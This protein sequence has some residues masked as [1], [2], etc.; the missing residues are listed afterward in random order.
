MAEKNVWIKNFAQGKNAT[1]WSEEADEYWAERY[2]MDEGDEYFI[3]G[4]ST[5]NV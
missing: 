2:G 5:V 4:D 1:I 3:F